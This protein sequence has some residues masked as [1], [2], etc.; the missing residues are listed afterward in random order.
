[1]RYHTPGLLDK[2]ASRDLAKARAFEALLAQWK[3]D[4]ADIMSGKPLA[5][6]I[7]RPHHTQIGAPRNN[8]WTL[9]DISLLREHY[10]K[11]LTK[12]LAHELRRSPNAVRVQARRM[13]LHEIGR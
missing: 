6:R 10:G 3:T 1:M 13:G 2:I 5:Y 4:V 7:P 9:S 8:S 11:K 12:V